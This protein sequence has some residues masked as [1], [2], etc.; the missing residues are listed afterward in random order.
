MESG[1]GS[2]LT[3]A[4]A[5]GL[6]KIVASGR[7]SRGPSAFCD[8]PLWQDAVDLLAQATSVAIVS[9][10]YIPSVSAP[11][12]DG[13]TGA[14]VL[15]RALA[16]MGRETE[17]WT[18]GLCLNCMRCCAETIG[19]SAE[20]V[21][22]ATTFDLTTGHPALLVYIERPGRATDSRYYNMKK[23][24]ISDWTAPLDSFA[25]RGDIPVLAVGDGGN[26]TGMGAIYESLCKRVPDY[27][28]CL[29][30]VGADVCLPV[31]VSNW[32]AYALVAAMSSLEGEWLGQ[33][34]QEERAMLETLRACG[35]VD[36]VSKRSALSVDGLDIEVQLRVRDAL[37]QLAYT[38]ES[39][40]W[41]NAY[42]SGA[43]ELRNGT[44][45]DPNLMATSSSDTRR[46]MPPNMIFDYMGILLNANAAQDLNLKINFDIAG[47]AP[48]L[49]TVN[50][51]VL[52]HQ[53]DAWADDADAT[54]SLEK[55]QILGL[56][57]GQT[58][59]VSI[60]GDADVIERLTEHMVSFEFFFPIVEP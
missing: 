47:E 51:G 54:L 55:E 31:D 2:K 28:N 37:E 9:G 24:D 50:S 52:L 59:G 29:C 44:T 43:Q 25:I 6:T 12:T 58:E 38:A 39:G 45:N 46:A 5:A 36:G 10:F 13:P 18:D 26:E 19:F 40:T 32:G 1:N 48:Y 60:Q 4:V 42:L 57:A 15:A 33:T 56:M 49:V 8:D 20:H 21:L 27:A 23:E 16:R 30:V 11:E 41:R 7:T 14:A 17:I 53:A 34:A 35:A 3:P 22:D